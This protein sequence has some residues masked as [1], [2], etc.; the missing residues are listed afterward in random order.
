MFQALGSVMYDKK[1]KLHSVNCPT[2]DLE[3]SANHF[4]KMFKM[5]SD[6]FVKGSHHVK[7]RNSPL[8]RFLSQL[9][10]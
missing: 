7:I 5:M 9:K 2:V 1:K 4:T 3:L 8:S 10:T 6:K